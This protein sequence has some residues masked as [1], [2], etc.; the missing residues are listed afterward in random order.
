M[1]GVIWFKHKYL[2]LYSDLS[3][4]ISSFIQ[5]VHFTGDFSILANVSDSL[6]ILSTQDYNYPF[7]IE[8]LYLPSSVKVLNVG[9]IRKG[10]TDKTKLGSMLLDTLD[11]DQIKDLSSHYRVDIFEYEEKKCKLCNATFKVYE[12]R[13]HLCYYE[14]VTLDNL[15]NYHMMHQRKIIDFEIAKFD[16]KNIFFLDMRGRLQGLKLSKV[17]AFLNNEKSEFLINYRYPKRRDRFFSKM[18]LEPETSRSNF[19]L[20]SQHSNC[21]LP[22]TLFMCPQRPQV[23]EVK[24]SSTIIRFLP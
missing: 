8:D 17:P 13:G 6:S 12:P 20:H 10:E 4:A 16:F 3:S 22:F 19:N 23:H 5:I 11:K 14:V 7:S 2:W 21:S 9:V 18:F 24:L 15:K 1:Y